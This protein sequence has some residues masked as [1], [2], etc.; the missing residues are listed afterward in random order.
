SFHIVFA[1]RPSQNGSSMA[2]AAK[3]PG[4]LV[5]YLEEGRLKPALVVREQGEKMVVQDG[6]GREKAVAREL[7]LVRHPER[8]VGADDLAEAIAALQ[9]ERAQLAADLDL[10][11]L[12]EVVQ[13]QGRSFTAAEL[14]ELFFGRRSSV[15]TSVMLEALFNDRVYF[16]RRHMEFLARTREQVERLRIQNEK[17]RMRSEEYRRIQNLVRAVIADGGRPEAAESAP[18][19]EALTRYLKNPSTRS[20]ELG[21]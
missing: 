14:A 15:A 13:E 19:V 6:S 3:Y 2:T 1:A 12:W 8:R 18:I 7:V 5:E 11:L 17:V 10:N 21:A 16:I 9:E 4:G 20:N